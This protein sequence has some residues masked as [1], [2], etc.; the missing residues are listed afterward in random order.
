MALELI[1]TDESHYYEND[2]LRVPGVSE[3]LESA[4]VLLK[5]S[6]YEA[7]REE[8]AI[9]GRDV[10][11]AT[12]DMDRGRQ[13]WWSEDETIGPYVKAWALFKKDFH[14]K[15]TAIEKPMFHE[16]YRYA[17]TPDRFGYAT[18]RDGHEYAI[19]PD[20]KCVSKV[21]PHTALQLAAYNLMADDHE[22]RIPVAVQLK[23]NGKYAAFWYGKERSHNEAVFLAALTLYNWKQKHH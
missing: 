18:F 11:M 14:F 12:S 15:P 5:N 10:H 1:E 7:R 23:P 4:A 9:R 19:T 20:I 6:F 17:G 3:I 2:G 21:G 16:L 8:A 22:D 13:D